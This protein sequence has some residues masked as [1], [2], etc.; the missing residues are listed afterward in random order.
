MI[1]VEIT[2]DGSFA[3]IVV[4]GRLDASSSESFLADVEKAIRSGCAEIELDARGLTFVSSVGL[5]ALV[6][7]SARLRSAGGALRVTNLSRALSELIRSSRL[8][9]VLGVCETPAPARGTTASGDPNDGEARQAFGDPLGMIGSAIALPRVRTEMVAM[10]SVR[11]TRVGDVHSLPISPLTSAIA[12]GALAGDC[13]T[14]QGVSGELLAA[15]GVAVAYPAGTMTAD[16]VVATGIDDRG[17]GVVWASEALFCRGEPAWHAT[18]EPIDQCEI[19]LS[20]IVE[21]A[22]ACAGGSCSIVIAGEA[23]GLVGAWARTAPESWPR[24][25]GELSTSELKKHV[26]FSIERIGANDTAVIVVFAAPNDHP[27][28]A[29]GGFLHAVGLR[30]MGPRVAAHAHA[31]LLAFRP[32]PPAT[33]NASDVFAGVRLLLCEQHPKI[34]LHLVHDERVGAPRSAMVRGQAWITPLGVDR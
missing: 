6:Q 29:P 16:F 9:K 17:T 30:A 14:A 7:T 4:R 13:D 3:R 33:G 32:L 2:R 23:R 22:V 15:A 5:G 12:L 28:L 21:A 1:D 25:A 10:E 31:T 26:A 27:E 11:R 20:A 24:S 8:E 34:V 19:A 18:F